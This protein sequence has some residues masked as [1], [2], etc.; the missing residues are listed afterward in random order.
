MISEGCP[1]ADLLNQLGSIFSLVLDMYEGDFPINVLELR[2]GLAQASSPFWDVRVRRA[3][4]MMI[5]RDLYAETFSSLDVFRSEGF[6]PEVRWNSHGGY[7]LDFDPRGKKFGPPGKYYSLDIA[8]A[9]KLLS[10]AGFPSGLT[11]NAYFRTQ[12]SAEFR[13][14]EAILGMLAE[15]GVRSNVTTWDSNTEF[16]PRVIDGHGDFDGIAFHGGGVWPLIDSMVRKYH[17]KGAQFPGFDP[18]GKDRLRGDPKVD[19]LALKIRQEFDGEKRT[20][21][22]YDE[23]RYLSDQMYTVTPEAGS[24]PFSSGRVARAPG[25]AG[26][27]GRKCRSS[28]VASCPAA[29]SPACP[30]SPASAAPPRRLP[31]PCPGR[32]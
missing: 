29:L 19:D 21:L 13:T 20:E 5:D 32:D 8:E 10:A 30:P 18:S 22:I 9:K 3:I 25:R 17:S 28:A 12:A 23:V 1:F 16:F 26:S 6:D 4:S 15:G 24:A 27:P 2:F 14:Y 7:N 11:V 31:P